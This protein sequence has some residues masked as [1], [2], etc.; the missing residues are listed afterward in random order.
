MGVGGGLLMMSGVVVMS[1]AL[2][3]WSIKWNENMKLK[4]AHNFKIAKQINVYFTI[5]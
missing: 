1:N 3:S 5:I 2:M 4:I